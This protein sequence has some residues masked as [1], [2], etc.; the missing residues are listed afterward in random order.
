MT[1]LDTHQAGVW[2]ASLNLG[3]GS[4]GPVGSVRWER[5]FA[6][7]EDGAPTPRSYH[8]SVVHE[9]RKPILFSPVDD[10]A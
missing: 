4:H 8:T 6:T 9:V 7:N 10:S 1:P 3:Q 2:K 5:V